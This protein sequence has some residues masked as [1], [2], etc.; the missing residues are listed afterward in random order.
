MMRRLLYL[1]TIVTLSLATM[2]AVYGAD[3]LF[4]PMIGPGEEIF[5]QNGDV[6]TRLENESLQFISK[7]GLVRKEFPI[8]AKIYRD[9]E[10]NILI[11]SDGKTLN[12]GKYKKHVGILTPPIKSEEGVLEDLEKNYSPPP[13][14]EPRDHLRDRW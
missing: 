6:V 7:D 5:L 11:V 1:A 3:Q 12:L 9:S 2:S 14:S 4:E 10:K 8:E 13:W